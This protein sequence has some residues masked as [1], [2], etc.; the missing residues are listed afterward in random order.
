VSDIFISYSRTDRSRVKPLVD[1]LQRRGWSVWWDPTI[2]PGK[3]WDQVIEAA[4]TAARCV[5]VLWSRDSIQSHWVRTEAED[6]RQRGILV[7]ALL[8]DVI[9]PLAFRRIQAAR[10][11]EWSN[12]LPNAEF[13]ELI[14]AVTEVLSDGVPASQTTV[15]VGSRLP[16][17]NAKDGLNYVFIPAGE[18]MMGRSPGD[19]ECQDDEKPARKVTITTGFRM[20]QTPVTQ[21]AYERVMGKNPSHFKGAQLPVETVSWEDA[22]IYCQAV[23][24]RLPT[25]SEWEHA[26]RAGTTGS[27]YG[28]IDQI[29]WY[30]ANSGSKTHEVAQKQPNA[31]GLY[32]MLGNVWEWTSDNYD[33]TFKVVRGGSWYNDTGYVRVSYRNWVVPTY[34][35]VYFGFRCVGELR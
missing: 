3:T 34:R 17:T 9:I 27:R 33:E 14:L 31:W 19:N 20:G 18:F 23:G 2:R 16:R 25:E 13:D 10:L 22:Q 7:P 26:A 8:D 1:E 4:L 32:D 30:R 29:A 21:E 15:G 24:M 11:V 5:I 28:D 35:Y 12:A 6:G